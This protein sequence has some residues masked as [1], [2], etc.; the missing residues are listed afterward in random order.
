MKPYFKIIDMFLNSLFSWCV[1]SLFSCYRLP[2]LAQTW[3]QTGTITK[4]KL[5]DPQKT[6]LT[7]NNETKKVWC[8]S[9]TDLC[10]HH[11]GSLGAKGV[12]E[13]DGVAKHTAGIS[14]VAILLPFTD[15][16]IW[17]RERKEMENISESRKTKFP[18]HF[19][20]VR[21]RK[22]RRGWEFVNEKKKKKKDFT[23]FSQVEG[24]ERGRK[25]KE[26]INPCSFMKNKKKKCPN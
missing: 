16:Q 12:V 4:Q 13:G 26:R 7:I 22:D 11:R 5:K 15:W 6:Q 9:W 8:L 20:K 21:E 10:L 2:L 17:E 3:P 19:V 25:R 24:R 1:R 14:T 18:R 23:R